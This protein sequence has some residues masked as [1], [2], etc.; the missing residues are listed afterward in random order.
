MIRFGTG[1]PGTNCLGGLSSQKTL[2]KF[3][4]ICHGTTYPSSFQPFITFH[5]NLSSPL[6]SKSNKRRYCGPKRQ[7]LTCPSMY[8]GMNFFPTQKAAFL[9]TE[10]NKQTALPHCHLSIRVACII[11]EACGVIYGIP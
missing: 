4:R 11:L 8:P 1:V 7:V 6:Y 2:P 3:H 5:P 10:K 9:S